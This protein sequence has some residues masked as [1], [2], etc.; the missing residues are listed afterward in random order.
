MVVK[1]AMRYVILL[2]N[3]LLT[4]AYLGIK[5]TDL[6]LSDGNGD[7]TEVLLKVPVV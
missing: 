3:N 5:I 2:V 1:N 7:C 6:I 4:L